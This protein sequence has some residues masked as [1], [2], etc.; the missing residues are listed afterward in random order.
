MRTLAGEL[1][2]SVAGRSEKYLNK[3][4]LMWLWG[5]DVSCE[6]LVVGCCGLYDSD[7]YM[8]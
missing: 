3:K 5:H 8:L 6:S 1:Q 7:V 4:H 2:K